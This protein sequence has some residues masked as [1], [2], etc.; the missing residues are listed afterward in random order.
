[1][2]V[3]QDLK[4]RNRLDVSKRRAAE[5]RDAMHFLL[6]GHDAHLERCIFDDTCSRDYNSKPYAQTVGWVEGV[7]HVI[8]RR[9]K[10]MPAGEDIYVGTGIGALYGLGGEQ[11]LWTLAGWNVKS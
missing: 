10:A 3:A 9:Q 1:M 6:A 4:R 7:P 2:S 8:S 5:E 11:H